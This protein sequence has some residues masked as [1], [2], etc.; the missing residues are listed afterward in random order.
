MGLEKDYQPRV[1][2]RIIK[3]FP[4]AKTAKIVATR[5]QGMPDLAIFFPD[6]RWALLEV[7][8]HAN[9]RRQPNQPYYVEEMNK[10][11]YAAF[12]YPENE[13]QIFDELQQT[14]GSS[15]TT[16]IS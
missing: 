16:R 13:D 6:G 14:F 1:I 8:K 11:S 12:I 9:A 5:N 2:D 3:T 15:R 4:G 10:H 7:K